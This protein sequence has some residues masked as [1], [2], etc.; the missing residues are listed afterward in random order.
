ML[1]ITPSITQLTPGQ[2]FDVKLAVDQPM[3]VSTP[4]AAAAE[5]P[6]GT[7]MTETS[8]VTISGSYGP[9]TADGYTAVQDAND[10]TLFHLTPVAGS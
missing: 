2:S 10:P 4:L 3:S 7:K 8:T 6:N 9:V 1:T 5:L